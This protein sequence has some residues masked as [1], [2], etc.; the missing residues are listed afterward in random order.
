M[1]KLG[2]F[3][4]ILVCTVGCSRKPPETATQPPPQA[5]EVKKPEYGIAVPGKPGFVQSPYAPGS[6]YVD[7]RGFP[8]GTEVKDPYS[9]R[10]FLVPETEVPIQTPPA[11]P[12]KPN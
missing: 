3:L 10:I 8:K 5:P 11:N 4:T 2:L 12:A 1:K 6:G 9:G 7:V